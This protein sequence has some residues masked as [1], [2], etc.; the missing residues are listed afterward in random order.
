MK[1]VLRFLVDKSFRREELFIKRFFWIITS[2]LKSILQ[3]GPFRVHNGSQIFRLA[4]N[5]ADSVL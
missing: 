2:Y 3:L 5:V 1:R 4:I